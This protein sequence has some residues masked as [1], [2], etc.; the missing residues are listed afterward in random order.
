[1]S[2]RLLA[3]ALL[4]LLVPAGWAQ[5]GT[6][7]T[8]Q[9]RDGAV[10]L[11]GRHLPDAVP[12]ALDLSGMGTGLLEFA[13]P[14]APVIEV[15]GRVYVLEDERLVPLEESA[16]SRQSVYVLGDVAPD[17]PANLPEERVTP[18]VEAAYMRDVAARNRALY[19]KMQ[20]MDRTE[21]A[22][23]QLAADVRALPEGDE[24]DRLRDELRER[25]SDVLALKREVYAEE[26][27]LAQDRLDVL[28]ARL[29][30]HERQ[31]DAIVDG[32]LRRLAGQ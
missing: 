20:R 18:I 25:L 24:R 6:T 22:A 7:H 27:A 10:Y 26:L 2:R 13:G 19:T 12:A 31:H 8:F 16:Q 30:E 29:D 28:R 5:S 14:V 17:V 9:I 11:N 21:A 23:L 4:V 32:Q 3:L 15:D 1:M